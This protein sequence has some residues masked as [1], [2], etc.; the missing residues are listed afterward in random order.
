MILFEWSTEGNRYIDWLLSGLG[1]T[2]ALALSAGI[3]AFF[4]GVCLGVIQTFKNRWLF[5]VG[6][7]YIQ[8]F[9][10]IPLLVQMFIGYFLVPDLLP[11]S[12]GSAI[13]AMPPPWSSF[14]PAVLCLGAY[15]ASRIGVHVH[16]ALLALPKGQWE[17]GR[18]L[19][20]TKPILYLNIL[21]PQALRH[22][23]PILMSE[24]LAI[25]KNTSV[26]LTIGVMELTAQARHIS[27]TTFKTFE[28]FSAATLIYLTLSLIIYMLMT[29]I[30]NHLA[31]PTRDR[32]HQRRR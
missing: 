11:N 30:E 27:E 16:T 29:M 7:S 14:L 32:Y 26:A 8:V 19:G 25:F 9:R 24:S 1:W 31:I 28:A 21:L 22:L 6:Y 17:A 10:N 13:K 18:A 2:I 23:T 20:L 5:W 15:T 3:I 12:L 4:L